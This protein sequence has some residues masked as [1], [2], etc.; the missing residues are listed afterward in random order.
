M[1]L[2]PIY[3]QLRDAITKVVP[4]EHGL[5]PSEDLPRVWGVLVDVGLPPGPVTLVA[6]ADTTTS[7][8]LGSGGATV[9]VGGVPDVAAAARE[10]LRRVDA[11][12][13]AF[14]PTWETPI[15]PE[16]GV[17][18]TA[19]TYQGMVAHRSTMETLQQPGN[20]V[21]PAWWQTGVVVGMIQDLERRTKREAPGG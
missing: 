15:P 10:L 8:Y 4:L 9:G 1:E 19:L 17:G 2:A 6:I 21:G 18:F 20:P 5:A 13:G 3:L 7:F 11:A 14:S 12:L 16:G